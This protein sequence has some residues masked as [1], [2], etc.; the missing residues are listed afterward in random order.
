MAREEG[1]RGLLYYSIKKYSFIT[2]FT[3]LS[4]L[5]RFAL[6]KFESEDDARDAIQSLQS[7]EINGRAIRIEFDKFIQVHE[8]EKGN[9]YF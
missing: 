1:K 9:V 4:C 3:I 7:T 6:I 5:S 2:S 8:G